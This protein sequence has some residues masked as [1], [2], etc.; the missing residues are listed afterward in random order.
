ML[1]IARELPAVA[2]G[3]LTRA[4]RAGYVF[5]MHEDLWRTLTLQ[6]LQGKFRFKGTWKDTFLQCSPS[7][8][9][10]KLCADTTCPITIHGLYSDLLYMPWM[11]ASMG[12]DPAWLEVENIDRRSGLTL[13]AFRDEYERPNRPVIITD[14]VKTWKAF[15]LWNIQS[16]CGRFG[17][18]AF[19]VGGY[20]MK[21]NDF[22][23]YALHKQR[24]D[25]QPLCKFLPSLPWPL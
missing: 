4:S 5:G 24:R 23:E 21:L 2:L 3:R 10:Q 13:Q 6:E 22:A 18:L 14:I 11:Y 17:E 19:N 25:D 1:D 15:G 16:L 9:A 8:N 20:D 12:I 7:L